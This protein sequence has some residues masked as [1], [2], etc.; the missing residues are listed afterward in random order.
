MPQLKALRNTILKQQ[1]VDSATLPDTAKESMPVDT[2][3]DIQSF[4][5]DNNHV[6]FV[7]SEAVNGTNTWFA[8]QSHVQLLEN[9]KPISLNKVQLN[10]PYKSQVDNAK[11]PFGSCNCTS[12]AMGLAFYGVKPKNPNKQLED[13]LQ[14]WLE[15]RGLDRHEPGAMKAVYEA[16]GGKDTFKTNATEQEVK[17]WL[18]QGNPCVTHGYFTG[19]GHIVCLIGYNEKGF[20]VHDPYG[21]WYADGYDRNDDSRP[22]KGKALTYSYGM[23][24][25][26]CMTGGEFWVH[27]LSK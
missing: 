12:M 4:S 6:K 5:F 11:N 21:E 20:I 13:E 7:L 1:P 3:F 9:G 24:R 17:Q 22:E 26:T 19:S 8:F 25:E 10:V 23:M 18:A 2:I 16:Y 27:F 14:E 15:A